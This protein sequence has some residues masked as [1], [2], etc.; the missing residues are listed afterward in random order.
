MGLAILI[1]DD[2]EMNRW[3]LAEQLQGLQVEVSQTCNGLEAWNLLQ[4]KTFDMA[5][6]DL[7]M[8][9]IGGR[10]LVGKI[11]CHATLDKLHCV[12]I[13]AHAQS[14]LRQQLLGEGFNECLIKPIL[15]ADLHRVVSQRMQ[16][17]GTMDTQIYANVLLD[18]V[19]DNRELAQ[20]LLNKLFDQVPAQFNQLQ[21]QLQNEQLQAAWEVA[22]Q[23][24]GTFCFYGFE[25]FR[26]LARVLEQSLTN[27]TDPGDAIAQLQT[28]QNKFASLSAEQSALLNWVK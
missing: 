22:H 18:R 7:N 27:A 15:L 28:L 23:L 25:D 26:A 14:D 13:T 10:E 4:T 19:A 2:N 5:F 16:P 20:L 6:F 8:P 12:A 3:L 24:H 17:I 21:Q 11:R 9:L 1:A